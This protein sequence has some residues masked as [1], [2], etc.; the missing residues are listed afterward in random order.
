MP[1]SNLHARILIVDDDEDDYFLTSE[2]IRNIPS[3]GFTIDWCY[4]Y[5]EAL[6]QITSKR[7]DLYFIDYLL[8]AKTGLELLKEVIAAG[9]E[10]PIILLTGKG[11][12]KVDIEAMRVG[13]MDYLVKGELS[14]EKLERSIRYALERSATMKA[15]RLNERKYRS[16]FERSKDM[17]F[18]ADESGCFKDVNRATSDLLGYNREELMQ[19]SIYNLFAQ[20]KDLERFRNLFTIYRQVNDLEVEIKTRARESKICIISASLETDNNNQEYMQGIVHDITNLKKAEK[21][22]LQV[23]K[24]AAAG[25]LVRTLAHEV[26]NPLNNINLSVEHLRDEVKDNENCD[27]YLGIIQRNSTRIGGLITELLNSSRQQEMKLEPEI[28][29]SILDESITDTIDRLTLQGINMQIKYPDEPVMVKVDKE[30]LKL[31]F[32]NIII[33]ATEA[34]TGPGGQISI[35]VETNEKFNSVTIKDNGCGISEENISRLF[36][37][38]FTSKRNGMGL[39]LASTLNIVQSNKAIIDVKSEVNVGTA[40]TITFEKNGI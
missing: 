38:Y 8:G 40:F 32:S 22:T 13:A 23:E 37:P 6:E 31:A 35:V 4:S 21:A 33:N 28:L 1:V 19:L 27:L 30:K 26:R 39:G 17:V 29:Q 15:L 18:I 9:V 20:K 5:K 3:Q 10:E 2:L 14:E 36:E 25:R 12:Q 16:M 7:H 34:I 11:N 24:L